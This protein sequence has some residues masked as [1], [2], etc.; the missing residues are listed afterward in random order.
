VNR[1]TNDHERRTGTHVARETCE[2]PEQASLPIKITLYRLIQE[3]LSNA[4][5]HA[6]GVGQHVGVCLDG[7]ALRVEVRD[8][9][10]GLGAPPAG[11]TEEHLGLVGMRERVESMGGTFEIDSRPGRGTCIRARLP[12]QAS[13]NDLD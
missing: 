10:P 5:H 6:A 12:L 13:A 8:G 2:L 7:G 3:A 11:D 9:G 4:Y 1:V